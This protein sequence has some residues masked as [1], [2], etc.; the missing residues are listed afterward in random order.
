[1]AGSHVADVSGG[2]LGGHM[3][4]IRFIKVV[5]PEVVAY[6]SS[7][8]VNIIEPDYRCT[9]CGTHVGTEDNYCSGCG[10][11]L[12]FMKVGKPSEEFRN[13]LKKL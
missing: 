3:R 7:A 10:G 9:N 1:M 2:A 4:K 11:E 13:L 6:W 5:V 8:G 12:D